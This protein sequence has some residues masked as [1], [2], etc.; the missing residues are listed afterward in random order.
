MRRVLPQ[1]PLG[2]AVGYMRNQWTASQRYLTDSRIPIDNS[3]TEQDLRPLTVG[4]SNWK[5]LGHPQAAAGRLQLVSIV[6]SAVRHHLVVHDYLDHVLR[7]LA[8]AAQHHPTRLE[9]GSDYLLDLLPD[10]WGA[11]HRQSVRHQ[12]IEEQ[13]SIAEDKR[14]RRARQR[15]RERRRAATER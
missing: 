5:F 13:L 2:K 6:S 7:K 8:E 3:E 10:R 11:A 9:L 4:R 15:I 14:T 1:S 12:R